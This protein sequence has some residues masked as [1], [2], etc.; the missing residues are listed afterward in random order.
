MTKEEIREARGQMTQQEFAQ[1]I[2]YSISVVQSWEQ[3]RVNA[4]PR[5]IKAIKGIK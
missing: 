1:K 5:A 4:S 2:G 3:G